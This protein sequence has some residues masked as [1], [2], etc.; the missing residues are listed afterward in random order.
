MTKNN[1]PLTIGSVTINAVVYD[2]PVRRFVDTLLVLMQM[3]M[4]GMVRGVGS[5]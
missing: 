4:G 2:V 1:L 3:C 5:M